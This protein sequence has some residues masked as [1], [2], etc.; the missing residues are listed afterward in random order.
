MKV[1]V[2]EAVLPSNSGH[3]ILLAA[4]YSETLVLIYQTAWHRIPEN[5]NPGKKQMFEERLSFLFQQSQTVY[6]PLQVTAPCS[7][8]LSPKYLRKSLT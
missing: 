3:K 4:A 6:L 8:L 7:G 2:F 1:Y 5:C